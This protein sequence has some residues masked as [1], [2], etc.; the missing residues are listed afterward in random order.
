MSRKQNTI[1]APETVQETI[2]S[3]ETVQ[4]TIPAPETVEAAQETIPAPETVQEATIPAQE[5][6]LELP[7]LG[8]KLDMGYGLTN[9]A[10]IHVRASA[11]GTALANQGDL[12]SLKAQADGLKAKVYRSIGIALASL[13]EKLDKTVYDGFSSPK[14]FAEKVLGFS[15]TLADVV[16]S[17]GRIYADPNSPKAWLDMPMT[18]LAELLRADRKAALE[19]TSSGAIKADTPQSDITSFK[20]ANPAKTKTG[21]AKVVTIL[22]DSI[23]KAE[24][25]E[26]ELK[27]AI[28]GD[29]IEILKAKGYEFFPAD[30]PGKKLTVRVYIKLWYDGETGAPMTEVHL[31]TPKYEPEAPKPTAE[32][33]AKAATRDYLIRHT[34]EAKGISKDEAVSILLELGLIEAE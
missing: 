7:T 4:E 30:A 25:T 20:Q 33:T 24:G 14:Q 29:G 22:T 17:T 27:A 11:Y 34:M 13:P 9:S 12:L 3:P 19:A 16:V 6:S 1:P 18:N 8:L 23:T 31:M 21:K 26:E 5:A 10:L 2:L 28:S 15:H 32:E